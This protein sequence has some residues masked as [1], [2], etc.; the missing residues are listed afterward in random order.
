MRTLLLAAALASGTALA[1]PAHAV[2][3]LSLDINGALFN[4]VDQTACDTNPTVGILQTGVTTF[5]GVDFLGSSQT[6]LTGGINEL[7]TTSFQITNN[8]PGSVTYQLAVGGT[9]FVPPVTS[10]SL[11]GSG[12]F[13]NAIGSNIDLQYAASNANAQ[14]ADTPADLPGTLLADSGVIT[15][16]LATDSFNYNNTAPFASAG[17]Y[18]MSEGASGTLTAGAQLTGRS[19]SMIAVNAVPEPGSLAVLGTG[20][21]GLGL[22][23]RRRRS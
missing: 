20:I 18:S 16:T 19:Q 8:N 22:V 13:T 21:L 4:C 10:I 7:T 23:A 14:G 3:Q 5:N 1:T 9:D 6:Q 2:L 12:T 15:A 17:L 11:S